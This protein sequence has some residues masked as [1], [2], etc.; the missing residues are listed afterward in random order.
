[1]KL[2]AVTVGEYNLPSTI[3]EAMYDSNY[4][5]VVKGKKVKVI[6]ND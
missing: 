3:V 2:N 6:K 5:A 4:K 1:V